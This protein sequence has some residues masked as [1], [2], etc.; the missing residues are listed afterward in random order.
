MGLVVVLSLYKCCPLT[1]SSN[2]TQPHPN[3]SPKVSQ[4]VILLDKSF[5][6]HCVRGSV[7]ETNEKDQLRTLKL[8]G[9]IQAKVKLSPSRLQHHFSKHSPAFLCLA[10]FMQYH[11][12]FRPFSSLLYNFSRAA[13][14][15]SLHQ[16]LLCA[17]QSQRG[18]GGACVSV[19]SL[20]GLF[21]F[22]LE[23][24]AAAQ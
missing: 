2:H 18:G 16:D 7:M 17:L 11:T 15:I 20:T 14:Q 13:R 6:K 23:D 3:N 5:T 1:P 10:V 24:S 12:H 19:S 8:A 9:E 22:A 4:Y 21:Q